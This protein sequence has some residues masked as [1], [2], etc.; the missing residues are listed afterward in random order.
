MAKNLRNKIK[1]GDTMFIHDVN[2][3]IVNKF[4]EEFRSVGP[5]T[6]AKDVREVAVNSVRAR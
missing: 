3:T 6:A 4:V 2:P 1:K 5:V